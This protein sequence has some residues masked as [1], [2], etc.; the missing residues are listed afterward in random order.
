MAEPEKRND[1]KQ[2]DIDFTGEGSHFEQKEKEK[3]GE[4]KPE[5]ICSLCKK[6]VKDGVECIRCKA[7]LHFTCE[8]N[9]KEQVGKEYPGKKQYVCRKHRLEDEN[10]HIS[11]CEN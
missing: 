7:W 9:T 5:E 3:N 4:T 11:K 6:Y 1:N 2:T 8:K 10:K